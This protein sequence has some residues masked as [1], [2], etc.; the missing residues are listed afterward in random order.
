M[1]PVVV[2]PD[3]EIA[4]RAY[5]LPL[6]QGRSEPY[7]AG[8]KVSTVVGTSRPLVQLRR[9][10]GSSD[11]PG[12]DLARVDFIVYHDTDE[13]RMALAMLTWALL[14]AAASDRAGTTGVVSYVST[15]LGP[16]QMPD[17]ANASARVVMFTAD[18]LIRPQS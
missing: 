1:L 4:A 16:R 8:V 7:A 6:L 5:L 9:I 2:L 12:I 14:K 11:T 13:N 18:L 15:T 3:A 17:P 10:G